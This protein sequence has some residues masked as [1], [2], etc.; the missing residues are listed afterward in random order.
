MR[1]FRHPREGGDPFPEPSAC[2]AVERWIPAF[3]GMTAGVISQAS[4]KSPLIA[5]T[6]TN[7][8]A[9]ME[10]AIAAKSSTPEIAIGEHG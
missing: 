7:F 9:E 5:L 10:L 1:D 2:C 6:P 8:D 4:Y 3:A